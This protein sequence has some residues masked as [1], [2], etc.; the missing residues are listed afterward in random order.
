M[1]I[2]L[3]QFQLG[4]ENMTCS[5]EKLGIVPAKS[6]ERE[7]FSSLVSLQFSFK[8]RFP[9]VKHAKPVVIKGIVPG[10]PAAVTQLKPGEPLMGNHAVCVLFH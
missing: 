8:T 3:S 5:L 9:L 4:V 7:K 2:D 10:S 1:E 6:M